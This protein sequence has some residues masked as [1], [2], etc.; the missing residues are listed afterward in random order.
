MDSKAAH[1]TGGNDWFGEQ[2]DGA[3][4]ESPF[5]ELGK[6]ASDY[7]LS[8][9]A[10]KPQNACAYAELARRVG[11]A[12][13]TDILFQAHATLRHGISSTAASNTEGVPLA[14]M[15]GRVSLADALQERGAA[16]LGAE[17]VMHPIKEG[18]DDDDDDEDAPFRVARGFRD[19]VV[20]ALARGD[21]A[22]RL[23]FQNLLVEQ[24]QLLADAVRANELNP[25]QM[26]AVLL[27]KRKHLASAVSLRVWLLAPLLPALYVSDGA[28]GPARPSLEARGGGGGGGGDPYTNATTRQSLVISLSTLLC[29]CGVWTMPDHTTAAVDLAVAAVRALCASQWAGWLVRLQSSVRRLPAVPALGE[30]SQACRTA[31]ARLDQAKNM[32]VWLWA[33]ARASLP[34]PVG[35]ASFSWVLRNTQL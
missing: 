7:V 12:M 3:V 15:Y 30:T 35:K 21:A 28:A 20:G 24:C 5:P 16:A 32:P 11:T 26:E 27:G 10:L 23:K 18:G 1:R 34:L 9:I 25:E 14:A 29:H 6:S 31:A 8:C 33:R 22:R 13:E 19:L 2:E 17:H 4:D